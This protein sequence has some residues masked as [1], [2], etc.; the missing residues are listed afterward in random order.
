MKAAIVKIFSSSTPGHEFV[1]NQ[2]TLEKNVLEPEATFK[3]VKERLIN[4]QVCILSQLITYVRLPWL[5]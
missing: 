2:G 3:T 4:V 5:G 1:V